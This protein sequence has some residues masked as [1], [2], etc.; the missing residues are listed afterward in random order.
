[1]MTK[2]IIIFVLKLIAQEE[3][4]VTFNVKFKLKNLSGDGI[5]NVTGVNVTECQMAYQMLRGR[6]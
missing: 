2:E 6:M 3:R 5:S 1:M 4:Q